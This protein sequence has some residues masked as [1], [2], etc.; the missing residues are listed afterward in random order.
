MRK[1]EI[2]DELF[3]DKLLNYGQEPPAY[4]LENILSGVAG[5]RRKKKLIFWR[6][7]GVA[8][9]LLLAF[10]AGWQLN[11]GD[12]RELKQA[13]IVGQTTTPELLPE[14]K[15][16]EE[17]GM[18]NSQTVAETSRLASRGPGSGI[19][20]TKFNSIAKSSNSGATALSSESI[21]VA[22]NSESLLL[23]PLKG[24]CRLIAPEGENSNALQERKIRDNSPSLAPKSIDRQI[25]EQNKQMMMA[26]NKTKGKVRWLVGAQVSPEY[27]N[28][29]GSQSQV[30]ANNM[31]NASSNSVDF[32]G[33]ISVEYKK[34][35]RLS[36]Q[37]GV[38]YSGLG[39]S[40]GNSGSKNL[41]ASLGANYFSPIVNMDA[42]SNKMMMNSNAG[43]IEL[44]K[45][46]SGLVV[47]TSLED[48]P[49]NSSVILSPTNFIQN[50]EYIEIPLYLRY[51]LIDARFDVVMLGGFSSNVLVGNQLF[52]EGSSG[53]SL[54][55][56]TR[57][58]EALNYSGTLGMGFKYGLSKRISLNVEPR[59]KYFLNSL[60]SNLS[61]TYKPYTIGV[62][63]GL[64]Y[65]F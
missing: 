45:I 57:D 9:A 5:A 13:V 27:S 17:K 44:S 43:V 36:L 59:V 23:K 50:F 4:L 63:T 46:P 49:I 40:S 11:S 7:A 14:T 35:K 30:Y 31:L 26:G 64:S 55:G 19:R 32:G 52:V 33:G 12:G 24:L 62:F 47:G 2:L 18:P 34:G 8:A 53:K 20:T 60:N 15:F 22:T 65:E 37:S 58:M 16:Q 54:V 10:V 48:K 1:D 51:T 28:S 21:T 61:V 3:R 29:R 25:M 39:Q 6:V 41:E 38:Y 42:S 56:R